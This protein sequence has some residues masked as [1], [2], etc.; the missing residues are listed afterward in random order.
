[1]ILFWISLCMIM[2]IVT[3]RS[4]YHVI[5]EYVVLLHNIASSV[6]GVLYKLL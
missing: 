1:M 3:T 5:N 6:M 4:S 2:Q